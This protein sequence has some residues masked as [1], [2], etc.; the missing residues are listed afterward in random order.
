MAK[1]ISFI[2]GGNMGGAILGGILHA[3]LMAPENIVVSDV[4]E[5]NLAFLADTYKVKTT[6]NNQEAAK[7][8]DILILAVKPNI[9]GKVI[10]SIKEWVKDET[11]IVTIAAGI[12]IE[13]VEKSFEK[14]VKVIRT[15]PNTPAFVGAGMTAICHNEMVT[16][17]ELDDVVQIFESFGKVELIEEK[18]MDAVPAVSGSSPAYVFMFIEALGDGAVRSGIPREQAYRMAAQAVLGSAKM[19]LESGKHPG[20]LKDM[21]CSP[22]GTT[23]EA[24]HTL[25]QNNF[26]G[27]VMEAMESCTKKA[28]KMSRN[29]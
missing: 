2:G 23:I 26:R 19:V 12:N 8:A 1:R 9:Y 10:A 13:Y 28:I 17:E 7:T 11:I 18:L 4:N 27:A 25:E 14:K 3:N 16:K 24:V 20:A 21:V 29:D 6:K 5:K 15:M 22:A